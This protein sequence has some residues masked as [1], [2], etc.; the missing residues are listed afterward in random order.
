MM[1]IPVIKMGNGKIVLGSAEFAARTIAFD[2]GIDYQAM[3]WFAKPDEITIIGFIP[4]NP[5]HNYGMMWEYGYDGAGWY[6]F[7]FYE[8]QKPEQRPKPTLRE[9]MLPLPVPGCCPTCFELERS[10]HGTCVCPSFPY[11][12]AIF[13][14]LIAS[15]QVDDGSWSLM[16]IM[17]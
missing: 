15:V 7:R 8:S 12:L 9:V 6:R 16:W 2:L 10:I 1:G 5:P 3:S 17:R 11:R 4:Y 13:H 14:E